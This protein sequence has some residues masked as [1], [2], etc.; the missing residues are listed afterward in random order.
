MA[1]EPDSPGMTKLGDG[2]TIG[3]VN[4]GIQDAVIAGRD[5]I[6]YE[7]IKP[8]TAGALLDACQAQID[9]VLFGV[10]HKY[11]SGGHSREYACRPGLGRRFFAMPRLQGIS[12]VFL[13]LCVAFLSRISVRSSRKWIAQPPP[14]VPRMTRKFPRI[15]GFSEGGGAE[16]P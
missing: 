4:G 2:V 5:V 1:H 16:I 11:S 10:R 13:P 15:G 14:Q 12:R 3:D 7:G 8:V 9:D 6:I